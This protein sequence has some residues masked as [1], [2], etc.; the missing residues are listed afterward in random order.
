M[1]VTFNTDQVSAAP[2]GK[3]NMALQCQKPKFGKRMRE[4]LRT[5]MCI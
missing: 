2:G 3:A 4:T 5:G 1:R